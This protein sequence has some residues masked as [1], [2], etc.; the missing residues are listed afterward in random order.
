MAEQ[1]SLETPL[2]C[3]LSQKD[4]RHDRKQL[5]FCLDSCLSAFCI[6][7]SSLCFTSIRNRRTLSPSHLPVKNP[8]REN[9]DLGQDFPHQGPSDRYWPGRF[10]RIPLRLVAFEV[11]DKTVLSGGRCSPLA[12]SASVA[13][14]TGLVVRS[15]YYLK[16]WVVCFALL[17]A[18]QVGRMM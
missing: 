17:W 1:K 15:E 11:H 5:H 18:G 6:S 9:I 13:G 4:T 14:A 3:S 7:F 12:G 8:R 16:W 2:R 10:S